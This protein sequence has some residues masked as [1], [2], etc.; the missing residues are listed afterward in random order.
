MRGPLIL[1]KHGIFGRVSFSE[2]YFV[3]HNRTGQLIWYESPACDTQKGRIDLSAEGAFVE[4]IDEAPKKELDDLFGFRATGV[5]KKSKFSIELFSE[6]VENRESWMR[7]IERLLHLG[8]HKSQAKMNA[9]LAVLEAQKRIQETK[10]FNP[11]HT[12]STEVGQASDTDAII[13]NMVATNNNNNS[14]NL[15]FQ[16]LAMGD[17]G[18]TMVSNVLG[19]CTEVELSLDDI[20]HDTSNKYTPAAY[21]ADDLMKDSDGSLPNYLVDGIN[22]NPS[23][24]HESS[25]FNPPLP[26]DYDWQT[27]ANWVRKHDNDW[28]VDY[29]EHL[30][31]G[32]IRAGEL[33]AEI[34]SIEELEHDSEQEND[35]NPASPVFDNAVDTDTSSSGSTY[36]GTSSSEDDNVD[37]YPNLKQKNTTASQ[38]EKRFDSTS[39]AYYYINN[40]TG[41]SVW[42]IPQESSHQSKDTG[43]YSSHTNNNYS[44][45]DG[46]FRA[47]DEM[48]NAYYYY[49][50]STGESVWEDNTDT[51]KN[52]VQYGFSNGSNNG[53]SNFSEASAG[54]TS[55]WNYPLQQ[56]SHSLKSLRSFPSFVEQG[57]EQEQIVDKPHKRERRDTIGLSQVHSLL[58]EASDMTST[59]D[60]TLF[61]SG[62]DLWADANKST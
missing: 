10:T 35:S 46:W 25:S 53:T 16:E 31:T 52:S 5:S 23:S 32:E 7:S 13:S 19:D 36:T 37:N 24:A 50:E 9:D 2:K 18:R 51:K 44:E 28:G 40:I 41:E 15:D 3:V 39:N 58:G 8:R 55:T 26:P 59:L 14:V 17:S 6:T 60:R 49:N 57:E 45:N 4:V 1:V 11:E 48:Q 56:V 29:F 54:N 21:T 30:V 12:N 43:E 47:F 22:S 33:E 38:W 34:D 62:L 61:K 42:S 27:D 20:S